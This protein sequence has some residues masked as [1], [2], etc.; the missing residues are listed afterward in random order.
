LSQSAEQIRG[1]DLQIKKQVEINQLQQEQNQKL[2]RL[3]ALETLLS[4]QTSTAA[5]PA[6]GQ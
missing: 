5:R 4:S 1:Q 6:S 3:A 2:E